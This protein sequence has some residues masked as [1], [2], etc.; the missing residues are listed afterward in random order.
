MRMLRLVSAAMI[1]LGLVSSAHAELGVGVYGSYHMSDSYTFTGPNADSVKSKSSTNFGAL[2]FFPILP[3]FSLRGG[4]AY[5]SLNFES[6]FTGGGAA[7]D[8]KVNNMLIPVNLHF[9][10]PIVGLYAFGGVIFVSNQKTDPDTAGKMG[11]D[12]RTNLGLGYDFFNFTLFTLS[13]ELEYQKGSKN[14]SP[15]PAY[16]MKV[17]NMN[18]NLMA[19]FTF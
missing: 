15:D 18:L 8:S 16:D 13:G 9:E 1:F 3:Y 10:F 2:L 7:I 12:T 11:S 19:R 6:T 4:V 17:N 5:E 14:I